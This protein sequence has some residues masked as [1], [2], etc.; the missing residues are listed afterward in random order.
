MTFS[1]RKTLAILGGGLILAAGSGA[2]AVTRAPRTATQPWAMAGQYDDV[3]K[4]ALSHAILAPNPHNRQPWLVDLGT[5][6]QVTLFVDTTRLLPHTDPF[7]RQIVIGLGC[8]LENM[9]L[10]A[11]QDGYGVEID[12]FPEGEDVTALDQRPVAVARFIAGAGVAE[13]ALFD[14][15]PHRRS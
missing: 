1:R 5:P 14:Q 4:R 11:A 15:I 3:R 6:D 2:Y 10:A 13:P 7:S 12:T 9:V 8:F